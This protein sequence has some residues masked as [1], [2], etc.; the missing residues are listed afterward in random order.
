EIA[1]IRPVVEALSGAGV[2][3]SI[4][5]RHAA[6]MAAAAAAGAAVI[7]DVTALTGD[8]DS[9]RVAADSGL[10][11]VLMHLPGTPKTMQR[12]PRYADVA[13]EVYDYLAGR[14]AACE[15]AGI[16]AARLAVDPGIGFGK[17]ASH[18]CALIARLALFHGLG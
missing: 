4:D 13:F 15:E 11:V 8:P 14:I 10:P 5:T 2:R 7:N 3:V 18:N 6:V 16:P 17:L 1:R 12:D 9:P